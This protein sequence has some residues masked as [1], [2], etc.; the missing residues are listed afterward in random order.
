MKPANSTIRLSLK[1]GFAYGPTIAFITPH[2]VGLE[3]RE[4]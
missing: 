3:K 4:A 1:Q 2:Q